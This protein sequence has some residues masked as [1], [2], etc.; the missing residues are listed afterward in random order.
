MKSIQLKPDL[1]GAHCSVAGG[2]HNAFSEALNNDCQSMQIFTKN[3]RQW[4][5][6]PLTNE[7]IAKFKHT[8]SDAK[9]DHILVHDSY[10]INLSSPEPD[11]LELSRNAFLQELERCSQLGITYL[12]THPG[13]AL[14]QPR[15]QAI[16]LIAKSIDW[17][18]DQLDNDNVVILLENVAG[19][20]TNIGYK[21]QELADIIS[22]SNHPKQLG[23]CFDTCHALAAGYD[24][25]E[26]DGYNKMWQEFDQTIGLNKLKFFHLN[27][28][29]FDCESRKDRHEHIGLG[30]V[31]LNAFKL[32]LNDSRFS[33]VPKV[34]E[35]PKTSP[36]DKENLLI[37][38]KLIK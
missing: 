28:S 14:D 1:L 33:M 22:Q 23:V 6:K 34:L 15:E 36:G 37:L 8:W 9:I 26:L 21:F 38:R 18:L 7:E 29:K 10:L 4:Q 24:F 31:G 11:K 35:T 27:D 30:F 16:T 25:R 32:L 5:A 2:L 19:Q 13:S 3:E 12:N 17:A 20:G